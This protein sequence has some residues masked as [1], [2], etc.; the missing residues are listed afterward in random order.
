MQ[1]QTLLDNEQAA[2]FLNV[3]PTTLKTWRCRKT[4]EVPYFKIGGKVR[5][6]LSDLLAWLQS[7]K[8]GR[9]AAV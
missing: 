6:D 5:Y 9:E 4:F 1:T 3:S 7:R 8:V 2:K